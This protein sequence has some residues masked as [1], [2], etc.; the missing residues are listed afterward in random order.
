MPI[1]NLKEYND[2]YSEASGTLW[3]YERDD[4]YS[5]TDFESFKSNARII[6]RTPNA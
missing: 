6:G 5:E 1:Y 2:D 3:Q 4:P